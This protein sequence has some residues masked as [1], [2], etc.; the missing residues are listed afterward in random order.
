M[1]KQAELQKIAKEIL[2]GSYPTWK[3]DETE[4]KR[5]GDRK[6]GR[7]DFEAERSW[8]FLSERFYGPYEARE[9]RFR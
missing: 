2:E 4:V 6:R 8:R 9:E 3:V 1:K 7:Y 5:D